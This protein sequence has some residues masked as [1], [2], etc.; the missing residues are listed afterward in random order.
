MVERSERRGAPALGSRRRGPGRPYEAGVTGGTGFV[1][2]HL[3]DA[4]VAAGHSVKALTRREQPKL[5]GVEWIAG[6]LETGPRSTASSPKWTPSSTSP[7]SSP[8]E[9]GGVRAWQCR[10]HPRHA[11]RRDRGRRPSLRPRLLA[12][13]ARTEAFALRGFQSTRRRADPLFRP[14][15]VDRPPARGLRARR[16]GNARTVPHGQA[17]PDADAAPR[18]PLADPCPGSRRPAARALR[19]IAPSSIIIEPD[20]GKPR[21]DDRSSHKSSA[22]P[23]AR[24]RDRFRAG[25]VPQACRPRRPALP[26]R[27]RPSSRST[28]PL[29]SRTATGSSIPSSARLPPY[30][31]RKP[32]P[33]RASRKLRTGTASKSGFTPPLRRVVTA[34]VRQEVLH[35]FGHDSSARQAAVAAAPCQPPILRPGRG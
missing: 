13:G 4:A 29:T 26:R 8:P 19:P 9:C 1:G 2:S 22:G 33:S 16:Q 15:M 6:D 18:P 34:L 3:L 27:P 25:P 32:R 20:D 14:R 24:I 17:R 31:S 30:G 28:A 10:W 23:S 12:C 5:D 11:R 21:M 7:A 35:F